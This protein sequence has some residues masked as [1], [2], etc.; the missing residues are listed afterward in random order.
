MSRANPIPNKTG[1]GSWQAE[2]FEHRSLPFNVYNFPQYNNYSTCN[3]RYKI[4]KKRDH[5]YHK[6]LKYKNASGITKKFIQRQHLEFEN[7]FFLNT[8]MLVT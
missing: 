5:I 3:G 7:Y 8:Q 6:H 1:T 4:K 2:S